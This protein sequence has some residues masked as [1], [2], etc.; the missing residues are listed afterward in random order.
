VIV[1]ENFNITG[2][3]GHLTNPGQ[4]PASVKERG[5]NRNEGHNPDGRG[6]VVIV[7]DP[8]HNDGVDL[9]DVKRMQNLK[10]STQ[11]RTKCVRVVR[12]RVLWKPYL[13]NKEPD[14]TLV[15]NEDQVFTK[16]NLPQALPVGEETT[17]NLLRTACVRDF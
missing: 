12:V 10:K 7:L 9:E 15:L 3:F 5:D 2:E 16:D 1:R 13:V 8:P 6:V 4:I 17:L 14:D 11:G